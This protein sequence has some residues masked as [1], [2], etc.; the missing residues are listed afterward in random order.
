[1]VIVVLVAFLVAWRVTP[2]ELRKPAPREEF[3]TRV[4]RQN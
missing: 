1:M 4:D 3:E 2:A